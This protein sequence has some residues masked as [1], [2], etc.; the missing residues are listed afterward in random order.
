MVLRDHVSRISA[1]GAYDCGDCWDHCQSHDIE[2]LIPPRKK[3]QK[4][5]EKEKWLQSSVYCRDS[6]V[7]FQTT[8]WRKTQFKGFYESG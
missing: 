3:G 7:S 6:H 5:M 1:D 8:P 2:A 4:E